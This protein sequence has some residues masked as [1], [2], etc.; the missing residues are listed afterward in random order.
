M[1]KDKK[2]F[3]EFV[4]KLG[5]LERNALKLL[6]AKYDMN[7]SQIITMAIDEY[8]R[9]KLDRR[10]KEALD[11]DMHCNHLI[12]EHINANRGVWGYSSEFNDIPQEK[13]H[14]LIEEEYDG[15]ME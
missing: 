15:L 10:D 5:H 4:I 1:K 14:M 12:G 3:G 2:A 9:R 6:C 8:Y 13:K 7:P 11:D